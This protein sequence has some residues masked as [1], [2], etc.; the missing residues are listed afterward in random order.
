MSDAVFQELVDD[1]RAEVRETT[2]CPHCG[3]K[4]P[5][6]CLSPPPNGHELDYVHDDRSALHWAG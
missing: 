5:E 1:Y 2:D 3:V 4:A 6:P